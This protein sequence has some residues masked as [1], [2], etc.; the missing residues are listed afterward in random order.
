MKNVL[1]N[2]QRS[3]TTTTCFYILAVTIALLLISNLL[4]Y[5]YLQGNFFQLFSG[6]KSNDQRQILA[7]IIVLA[8]QLAVII[9]FI[10]WFRRAYNNLHKAG[11][12]DLKSAEGMAAGGWFIPIYSWVI[13]FQIMRE[14]WDETISYNISNNLSTEDADE[15]KLSELD[16]QSKPK[17]LINLWWACWVTS[18]IIGFINFQIVR[19][20]PS[21]K[22]LKTVTLASIAANILAIISI[23]L[24]IRIIKASQL[25]QDKFLNNWLRKDTESLHMSNDQEILD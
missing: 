18:N 3:K 17:T 20:T 9:T 22:T 14:I 21:I 2:S 15:L 7:S 1:D 6:A 8:A 25:D 4:Q 12:K 23:F 19:N 16:K 24:I 5:K 11:I 13:P 10:Q